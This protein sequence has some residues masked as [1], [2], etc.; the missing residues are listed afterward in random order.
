M[1]KPNMDAYIYILVIAVMLAVIA[2]SL[3]L[4]YLASKM[5][6]LIVSGMVLIAASIGLG[7]ELFARHEAAQDTSQEEESKGSRLGYLIHGGWVVAF[8]TGIYL[9]GFLISMPVFILLYM[10]RLGARWRTSALFAVVTPL[11][12]WGLFERA[13]G[14]VLYRGL[15]FD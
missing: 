9:V 13:I 11:I 2:M 12:I 10:K 8:F 7:K 5:L 6:P 1:K 14:L 3:G 15:F 4:P